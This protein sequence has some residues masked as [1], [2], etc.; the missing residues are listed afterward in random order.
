M[1]M[2]IAYGDGRVFHT[3][4][5]HSPEAMPCIGFLLTCVRVAERAASGRVTQTELPPDFS[6]AD[7]VSQRK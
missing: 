2:T 4:L 7:E 5:S 6:S 3:T 1:R